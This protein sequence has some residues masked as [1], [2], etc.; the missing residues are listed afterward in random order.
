MA[1]PSRYAL[2]AVMLLAGCH[3]S[4]WW[5]SMPKQLTAPTTGYVPFRAEAEQ[6]GVK[7]GPIQDITA[8]CDDPTICVA[9]VIHSQ[10][11]GEAS[12][13]RVFGKRAGATTLLVDVDLFGSPQR[14]RHTVPVQVAGPA[15]SSTPDMLTKDG[16]VNGFECT[17]PVETTT[18]R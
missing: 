5:V 13:V 7:P 11:L 17:Q 1:A 9:C 8:Q 12:E 18:A 6:G 4:T 16:N 14:E 15:T 3:P 2:I 10:K